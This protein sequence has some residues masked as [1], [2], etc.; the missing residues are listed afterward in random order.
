[1]Q[2][3]GQKTNLEIIDKWKQLP[4]FIILQGDTDTGKH[5]LAIYMCQKFNLHLV[6]MKNSV[7]E[8]RSLIG[9]MSIGANT[10]YYFDDFDKASLQAKNALLKIT[11]EPVQDNYIIIAGSRQLKTLESRAYKIIM[12]GYSI[13]DMKQAMT[14]YAVPLQYCDMLYGVGINTPSKLIRYKDYDH[15]VSLANFAVETVSTIT[16]FSMDRVLYTLSRFDAWTKE[17]DTVYLYISMM[18]NYIEYKILHQQIYDYYPMLSI[19]IKYRTMLKKDETLNR[20]FILYRLLYEIHCIG[21]R[22]N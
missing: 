17:Y 18:V 15:L 12:S 21:R 10:V 6:K 2:I 14:V 11:E 8:I 20:K 3:I 16:V 9:K 13:E 4:Q 19:M 7:S 5:Q 1:M 22:V